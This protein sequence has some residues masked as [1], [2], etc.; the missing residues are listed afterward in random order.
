MISVRE[1]PSLT[2]PGFLDNLLTIPHEF[3]VSQSFAIIDRPVAQS[4][5]D[6]VARQVDMSSEA[7]SVVAD[8]LG[9]ARDELLAS[10]SL[11]GEHHMTVMAL[12]KTL[13]EVD[14]TI[15]AA[16]AA[17]TDRSVIWVR[18]DLNTEPAF[19]AQFPGN[20]PYIARNAVRVSAQLPQWIAGEQSLG[21]GD[22]RVS[23]GVANG[24]L[25]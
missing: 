8:H 25:L 21:A 2:G 9:D 12:G 10:E 22:L 7:E 4:H 13:Q 19:W 18:E 23:D 3:V 20:F 11:Y 24:L 16:G 17:L 5:I 1:Y 15:T 6:R 14:A